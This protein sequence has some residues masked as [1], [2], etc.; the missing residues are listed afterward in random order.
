MICVTLGSWAPKWSRSYYPRK[1]NI[2]STI[3]FARISGSW[4]AQSY[5]GLVSPGQSESSTLFPP[6]GR[7]FYWPSGMFGFWE[8]DADPRDDWVKIGDVRG[9]VVSEGSGWFIAL[10][11]FI[12]RPLMA[13]PPPQKS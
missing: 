5:I 8:K 4:S 12:F 9:R 2:E 10:E 7:L 6:H 1:D 13:L 11:L 3:V